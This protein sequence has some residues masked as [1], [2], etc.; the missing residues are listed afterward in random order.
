MVYG[1]HFCLV[2]DTEIHALCGR[3]HRTL[4][5][6]QPIYGLAERVRGEGRSEDY[7]D[8]RADDGDSADHRIGNPDR[9]CRG[10]RDGL[11]YVPP[12]DIVLFQHAW[13]H[14]EKL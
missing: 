5:R 2:W 7:W 6:E 13:R 4:D 11:R 8:D 3:G 9:V 1:G 12:D 10:R 14:S